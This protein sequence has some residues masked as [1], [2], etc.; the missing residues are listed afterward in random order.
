MNSQAITIFTD[1]SSRKNPG[2][3]GW[4]AIIA[5]PN[6]KVTEIGG[7]EDRTTNNRMEL[8]AVIEALSH[9]KDFNADI[10]LYTDSSYVLKGATLWIK[11]WQKNNWITSTKTEVLNRDLWEDLAKVLENRESKITWHLIEGHVGVPA[12]QRADDIATHFADKKEIPLYNGPREQYYVDLSVI[13]GN[14]EMKQQKS[15]D[16]SHSK[17]KAYSYVSMIDGIVQT[18]KT[19]A[20][21]EA[22]VKGKNAK[23]KKAITPE[24]EAEIIRSWKR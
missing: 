12:N 2:P 8:Q 6:D 5:L 17:A 1:G 24:Q 7:H 21:C 11:S 16:R 13:S 23:F 22:R 14:A 18:H 3:G 15:S 9:V 19:W 4:A 10:H 20:E